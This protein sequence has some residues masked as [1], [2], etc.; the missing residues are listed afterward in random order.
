MRFN[1][2]S[3]K[4]VQ[5]VVFEETTIPLPSVLKVSMFLAVALFSANKCSWAS[6]ITKK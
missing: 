3:N 1:K 5:V 2:V 4:T 6:F